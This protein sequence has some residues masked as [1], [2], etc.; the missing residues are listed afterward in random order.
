[1]YSL[2]R[3]GGARATNIWPAFVDGLG[4]LILVFVFVLLL[5]T[6][7]QF[8]LALALSD[9]ES[10]VSDLDRRLAELS[11]LLS[12]EQS[13]SEGLR[14]ELSG[15][16]LELEATLAERDSLS[17]RVD[18]LTGENSR[19]EDELD[20]ARAG[21]AALA[22]EASGLAGRVS[23]LEL[24]LEEA[25]AQERLLVSLRARLEDQLADSAASLA[26]ERA[27]VG[28]KERENAGLAEEI[29]LVGRRLRELRAQL[30]AL[31]E[32]LEAS[33]ARN[34]EQEVE[35]VSLGSRLNAALAGR[36]QEL[37]RHR[38]EF[39][40]RLSEALGDNPNVRVVGDRFVL[41][42]EVLFPS[43]SADL[44]P[45]GRER[46]GR[47][48][49]ALR[50][51]AAE[52][53]PDVDWVLRVDGHTDANPIATDRFPSNWELSAARAIS[54]ARAL[55]AAGIPPTRLAAT[56]FAEH[57]PIAPGADPVSLARNRRIEFK[58]TER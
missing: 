13:A 45:E 20:A 7:S 21:G 30:A 1:M 46:I 28:E 3:T 53:P 42:A 44:G 52:I 26:R 23:E 5:F 32:A 57:R 49:A 10:E 34:R 38:S 19:L 41:P 54:V 16:R 9:S 8:F 29:A 48:S 2:N 17:A 6:F 22:E 58:L 33:E 4:T 11:E 15:L 18:G 31:Q 35:I 56:G 37:S 27:R 25:A 40:A 36:V 47:L 50:R 55:E 14:S 39:F 43:G 51:I 12:L 24:R